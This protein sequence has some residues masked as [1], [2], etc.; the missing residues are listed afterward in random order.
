MNEVGILD[1]DKLAN[2]RF[3]VILA[4]DSGVGKSS[5]IYRFTRGDYDEN[6][7]STI[8][9]AY[10]RQKVWMA[11]HSRN[12]DMDLWDTAG[13]ERFD[14]I[15][16]R[17]FRGASGIIVVFDM[18]NYTTIENVRKRWLEK[19]KFFS[20]DSNP[21][22]AIV[23]N[24]S[25]LTRTEKEKRE[26]VGILE[27]LADKYREELRLT[28][29]TYIASAKSGENVHRIFEGVTSKMYRQYIRTPEILKLQREV[30]P[31]RSC[32]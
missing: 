12:L 27:D 5:I 14:A 26:A 11:D 17:Y 9:V 28:V 1:P 24:K 8:G 22:I 6:V 2:I 31:K 25:D 18:T 10:S 21:V 13:Q 20:L 7:A 29:L 4:G 30:L 32:C 19:I 15:I 16:P 3:K 23:G